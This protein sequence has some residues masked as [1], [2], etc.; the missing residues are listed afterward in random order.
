MKTVKGD[1]VLLFLRKLGDLQKFQDLK[2]RFLSSMGLLLFAACFYLSNLLVSSVFVGLILLVIIYEWHRASYG[3]KRIFDYCVFF[4]ILISCIAFSFFNAMRFL[5]D[6]TS[7]I[8]LIWIIFCAV[9][10]DIGAYFTGRI[11]KGFR[12]FK[13]I[14]PNKTLSG[15]LGGL[16]IGGVFPLSTALMMQDQMVEY[17]AAIYLLSIGVV[18]SLAAMSGDLLQSY[19]KR[20]HNIKDMGNYLPGHGGF[21]DRFDGILA[22]ALMMFSIMA[23]QV[24]TGYFQI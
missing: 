17:H 5:L 3:H 7:E 18:L 14:S 2:L 16:I 4:Y 6:T 9:L 19:F 8:F 24:I 20:V 15:Y 11:I 12:P 1:L 10:S 23:Y 13:K 21:F 22:S